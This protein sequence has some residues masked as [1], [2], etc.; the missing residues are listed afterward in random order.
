MKIDPAMDIY[1]RNT[2]YAV[3]ICIIPRLRAINSRI[4]PMVDPDT[5]GI[6]LENPCVTPEA[7]LIMLTGPGVMDMVSE[8]MLIAISCDVI[9][10]S[11][12]PFVIFWTA[13]RI[14]ST[15]NQHER[16]KNPM[17]ISDGD[18]NNFKSIRKMCIE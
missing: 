2:G 15:Y 8:K 16:T 1:W 17:I 3:I 5:N 11:V 18:H 12:N 14:V 7:R 9:I 13:D 10:Y 6:V 4:K